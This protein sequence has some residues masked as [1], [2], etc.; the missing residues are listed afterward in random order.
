MELAV[1]PSMAVEPANH[2]YASE[3]PVAVTL[4]E[5]LEPLTMLFDCG[6]AWIAGGVQTVTVAVAL[7]TVPQEFVTRTK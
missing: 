6:C 4:S 5:V 1:A 3:V 7:S 2:W